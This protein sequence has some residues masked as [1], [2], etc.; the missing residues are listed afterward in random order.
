MSQQQR[1]PESSKSCRIRCSSHVFEPYKTVV[2]QRFLSFVAVA[3]AKLRNVNKLFKS[4]IFD[5]QDIT[6]IPGFIRT[7]GSRKVSDKSNSDKSRLNICCN[8]FQKVV[9]YYNIEYFQ[10]IFEEYSLQNDSAMLFTVIC[11]NF[12]ELSINLK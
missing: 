6:P 10:W 1:V 2:K 7:M 5:G 8:P 11:L 3:H 12:V 9:F 4:I